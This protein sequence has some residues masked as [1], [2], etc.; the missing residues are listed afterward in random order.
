MIVAP[1]DEE[2]NGREKDERQSE[3]KMK[4]GVEKADNVRSGREEE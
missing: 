4:R 3:E 1:E 2:R